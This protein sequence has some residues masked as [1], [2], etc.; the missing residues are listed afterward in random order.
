MRPLNVRPKLLG[1]EM[2]MLKDDAGAV[3]RVKADALCS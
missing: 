2:V 3:G 1:A